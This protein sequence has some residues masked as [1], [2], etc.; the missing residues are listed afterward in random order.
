MGSSSSTSYAS[1]SIT[2]AW[3]VRLVQYL[4][5]KCWINIKSPMNFYLCSGLG[6]L[7][8]KAVTL[9]SGYSYCNLPFFHQCRVFSHGFR[10]YSCGLMA[11]KIPNDP[12]LINWWVYRQTTFMITF[13]HKCS[14]D[15]HYLPFLRGSWF[16]DLY[17][18]QSFRIIDYVKTTPTIPNCAKI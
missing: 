14:V 4:T 1:D 16:V 6:A 17:C 12:L 13:F 15:E 9:R 8:H 2:M 11:R 18:K 10:C 7:S 5:L 3:E